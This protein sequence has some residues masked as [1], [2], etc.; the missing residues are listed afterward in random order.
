MF[1]RG[2]NPL[3]LQLT[4]EEFGA[5]RWEC[6]CVCVCGG[7]G[8]G[9]A[10]ART[11]FLLE[12]TILEARQINLDSFSTPPT[13]ENVSIRLNFSTNETKYAPESS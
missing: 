1:L 7:G 4:P 3:F 2:D 5:G 6:V 13:H 9:G 10:A 8:G 11:Y 12:E